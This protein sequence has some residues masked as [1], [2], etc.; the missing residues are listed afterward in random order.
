SVASDY[1][2][3]FSLH[4]SGMI[5]LVIVQFGGAFANYLLPRMTASL[6]DD[7]YWPKW[8]NIAFWML[9]MASFLFWGSGFNGSWTAYP[10][11]SVTLST[12]STWILS[13][14]IIGIS[15]TISSLN[16]FMTIWKGRAPYLKW[17]DLDLFVWGTFLTSILLIL[18]TPSIVI[19]LILIV[20]DAEFG[21]NFYYN[22]DDKML[23]SPVMYQHLFW[24]FAHPE[25]YVLV[26]PAFGLISHIISKFSRNKIF[27]YNG[28]V[29]AMIGLA[30][31]S[32]LVWAHHMY[33]TGID[34]MVRIA[35]TT[36]TFVIAV[37]S[38]IKV[39]NWLTTL[40]GGKIKFEAPML[41]TLSF[42][43]LF[44]FGGITGVYINIVVLDLVLHDTYWVVSHFHFVV[45]SGTLVAMFAAIYN[46]YPEMTGKM[47]NKAAAAI[48]FWAWSIG[49]LVAFTAFGVLGLESMPRRYFLYPN[50]PT[51]VLWHRIATVG[52]V[53]MG[54]SFIAF[55][56]A[57]FLGLKN[58]KLDNLDD[59]FG[60][61]EEYGG[62]NYPKPFSEYVKEEHGEELHADHTPFMWAPLT[63]F[64][65]SLPFFGILA[66][67]ERSPFDD[68]LLKNLAGMLGLYVFLG[69]F[70]VFVVITFM[71]LSKLDIGKINPVDK[72]KT[73][74]NYEIWA[75][76][77]SEVV[78]FGILIGVGLA[79]RWNSADG[80]WPN[81]DDALNV[82]LTAV[83][84]FF[85][86]ISSF[87]MAKALESIKAG[88]QAGLKK[89][90]LLTIGFGAT[91]VGIQ[92]YEYVE[93]AKEG[94]SEHH[95]S[96]ASA[97][98]LQTGFHGAHV[99]IGVLLLI[100]V[101]L[102]ARN[103][104]YSKEN[105][106]YVEFIGLYWHFVDLVWILLF[107]IIYL[108]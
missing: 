80:V 35:F 43:V 82:T 102:R 40:W 41:F 46:W 106:E 34:P 45:A 98:Y 51:L 67:V 83:N 79:M 54:I 22:V 55:I 61:G 63:G 50:D 100:F 28:M 42:I 108:I 66:Y 96:F 62:Y 60:L 91:F 97:F 38:G 65:L 93:L 90:L 9:P 20:F 103:G 32:F 69:L 18:S 25:V 95:P 94:F 8:N 64:A 3:A 99:T 78:F 21:T 14:V 76:L 6:N 29:A 19:A 30:T 47:Y 10:P 49:S 27:G 70:L 53:L 17:K 31:L 24:F 105:H 33:T 68:G 23:G 36:M 73:N 39:F 86:I 57:I 84:T 15:G 56:F 48:H 92:A 104:G 52:A 1:N 4:G 72:Y 71:K 107:T 85:L 81:P 37:P 77:G 11:L 74:R 88:D 75:F 87:T 7:M 58:P 101:Y 5:F 89:F 59:P 2:T 44:T 12:T 13:L 26:L 16:Y